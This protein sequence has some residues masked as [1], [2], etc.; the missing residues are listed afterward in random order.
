MII[1]NKLKV[2]GNCC[3]NNYSSAKEGNIP[4]LQP[5]LGSDYEEGKPLTKE[6]LKRATISILFATYKK[7]MARKQKLQSQ[8][9]KA[10]KTD[11]TEDYLRLVRETSELEKTSFGESK[12]EVLGKLKVTREAY[13]TAKTSYPGIMQEAMRDVVRAIREDKNM[14]R[15]KS[16]DLV[17]KYKQAYD[18][19]NFFLNSKPESAKNLSEA[20]EGNNLL[21]Y[22]DVYVADKLY[23]EFKLL[24]IELY[25]LISEYE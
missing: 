19:S 23:N 11:I 15:A 18:A 4:L 8:R 22:T 24:P 20:Y 13:D 2:M 21:N 5:T 12:T 16:L 17:H 10:L 25:A 14:N 7:N 1:I 6:H 9:A 3:P